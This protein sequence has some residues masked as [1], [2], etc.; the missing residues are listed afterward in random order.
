MA[1]ED[2]KE[3][4]ESVIPNAEKC[5]KCGISIID[6]FLPHHMSECSSDALFCL[7]V[8]DTIQR[9]DLF[10][11]DDGKFLEMDH[12]GRLLG[13]RPLGQKIKKRGAWFRKQND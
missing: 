7:D 13:I 8:G 4:T 5:P 1:K 6:V 10:Q 9:G 11:S 3:P 2:Q 12:L